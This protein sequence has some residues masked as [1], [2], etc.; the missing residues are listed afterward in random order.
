MLN[1]VK[2]E[3]YRRQK[4]LIIAAIILVAVQGGI[5][6]SLNKGGSYL[7]LAA[8]LV[9]LMIYGTLIL[10]MVD[11]VK[12]YSTDLN[13]KEG[14]MLFLTPNNGHKI[15][16]SK[17]MTTTILLAISGAVVFAF[18]NWN[19][20]VFKTL[21]IDT[22]D[23]QLKMMADSY[24]DIY[25]AALPSM[26]G[27]ILLISEL[28]VEFMAI[29]IAILFSITVRKTV[30]SH[31]KYGGLFSFLIFI[32]VISIMQTVNFGASIITGSFGN[33][34]DMVNEMAVSETFDA[35]QFSTLF[36]KIM[37]VEF[38]MN[39]I[40]ISVFTFLSGKLLTKRVDL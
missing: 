8:V 21:Y 9:L 2:Y 13:K 31:A 16:L 11:A 3:F 32:L 37:G 17:I 27:F 34:M 39:L 12:N 10:L 20:G 25:S 26:G 5:L 1:L 29:I 19:L 33:Y 22:M 18:M 14:F 15:I 35:S 38:A 28:A 6:F 30:L 23:G 36:G 40:Y 4:L 7:T 24:F